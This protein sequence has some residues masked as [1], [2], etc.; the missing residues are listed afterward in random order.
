MRVGCAGFRSSQYTQQPTDLP[1]DCRT[2][3]LSPT[4][5]ENQP[6]LGPTWA[7]F[8][9]LLGSLSGHLQLL[10]R[11]ASKRCQPEAKSN[12]NRKQRQ[13]PKTSLPGGRSGFGH[14]PRARKPINTRCPLRTL[15]HRFRHAFSSQNEARKAPKT[16]SDAGRLLGAALGVKIDPKW[17]N[18]SPPRAPKS[19]PGGPSADGFR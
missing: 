5:A 7:H 3:S 16:A 14:L 12:E 2:A 13:E 11:T 15:C 9:P 1:P 6:N 18:F 8:G 4:W 17:L 19:P 10:C